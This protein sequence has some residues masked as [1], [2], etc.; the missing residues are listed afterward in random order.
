QQRR[1]AR[2][3]AALAVGAAALHARLVYLF[4]RPLWFDEL[5]TLWLSRQSPGRIV[6]ALRVDPGP[7][8]FYFLEGPLA[9]LCEIISFDAVARTLPF[10]AI[11]A[12]F[13]AGTRRETS[14]GARFV[15][16]V[17]TSPL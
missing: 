12:L 3:Y 11:G 16:L 15:V 8:L 2:G 10:L 5:F 1:P 17:A 4:R 14:G 7:P 6:H 9:R 13:F